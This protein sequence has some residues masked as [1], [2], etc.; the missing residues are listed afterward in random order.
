MS[1]AAWI[2]AL[3]QLLRDAD[4]LVQSYRHDFAHHGCTEPGADRCTYCPR[5]PAGKDARCKRCIRADEIL[6]ELAKFPMEALLSLAPTEP[7]QAK[8]YARQAFAPEACNYCGEPSMVF[9]SFNPEAVPDICPA[10][11][12]TAEGFAASDPGP[13][14]E[15]TP[16]AVRHIEVGCPL[17]PGHDGDCQASAERAAPPK[18]T[19]WPRTKAGLVQGYR[20]GAS[21]TPKC[22]TCNDQRVI[23]TRVEHCPDCAA[24]PKEHQK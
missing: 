20:E 5:V 18:E 8:W 6:A 2:Q 23:C 9:F 15:L 1:I 14:Y 19:E 22:K 4:E 3:P 10:C 13:G 16:K 17:P 11:F 7:E 24:P 12:V 21:T